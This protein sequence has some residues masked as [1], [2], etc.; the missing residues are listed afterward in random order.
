VSG[1][2][3]FVPLVPSVS[4]VFFYLSRN[5]FHFLQYTYLVASFAFLSGIKQS[6]YRPGQAHR[7]PGS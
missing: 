1:I 2:F 4:D 7:D 6:L 5:I 3:R